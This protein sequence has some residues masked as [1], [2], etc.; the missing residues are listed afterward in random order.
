MV[1]GIGA[2]FDGWINEEKAKN[3]TQNKKT[4]RNPEGL[5]LS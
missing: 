3:I 2:V 1:N 5:F 4:F